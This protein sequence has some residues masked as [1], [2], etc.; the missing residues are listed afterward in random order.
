MG[1]SRQVVASLVVA[2][3]LAACAGDRPAL[4]VSPKVGI[5][6][7]NVNAEGLR[8]SPGSLRAVHYEFCIP[9]GER[10]AAQVR[11]IDPTAR[12]MPGSRGRSGCTAGQ[13]LVLG[14]THQPGY[15][16]VLGRLAALPYVERIAET[17]FE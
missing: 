5:D 6:L 1:N 17:H 14:N 11:G 9:E 10:Q 15:R 8:G 4:V 7:S 2:A 16:Q 12:V 13:A 3:L